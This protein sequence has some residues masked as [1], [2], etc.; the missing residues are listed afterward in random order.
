MY[1]PFFF[2]IEI[3]VNFINKEI[4][5]IPEIF[6]IQMAK[7]NT[8]RIFFSN[9]LNILNAFRLQLLQIKLRSNMAITAPF[10]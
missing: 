6:N 5:F 3:L 7:K 8:I 9:I 2:L 4:R 1:H 10:V